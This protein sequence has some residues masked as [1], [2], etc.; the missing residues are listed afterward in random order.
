MFKQEFPQFRCGLHRISLHDPIRKK[1]CHIDDLRTAERHIAAVADFQHGE[2]FCCL[3]QF[4]GT[5]GRDLLIPAV[6]VI[7]IATGREFEENII[8]RHE[9]GIAAELTAHSVIGLA[10]TENRLPHV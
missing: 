1:Q 10:L 3:H 4:S 2:F 7:L 8:L 9:L 6:P 5:V